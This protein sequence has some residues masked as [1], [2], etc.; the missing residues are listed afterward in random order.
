MVVVG[1]GWAGFGAAYAALQAGYEAVVL[2]AGEGPGGLA[3]AGRSEAGRAVE[4]GIKGFWYQY[5]NIESLVDALGL[6]PSS[7][8]TPYTQ[9][10]FYNPKGL[11]VRSPILQAQPRL[12]TPLGSFL[13]TAPYF[14]SLPLADRLTALPL[15]G[16]LLEYSSDSAAYD[17]Y[18]KMSALELFRSAGVSR[19]LYDEFLCPML[20]VTL[21]APGHKLSAAA[22]LDALYYFALAHQA[23]FD[24]R[25]CRQS[26]AGRAA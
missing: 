21:F 23:D 16:P 8:F 18:D 5:A 9:S 19:R 20:M 24:V 4:P 25:W 17:A 11:Q 15:L 22:A 26:R 7:I 3:G 14:T 13:Y 2:E 12:P 1:G 6:S 10:S